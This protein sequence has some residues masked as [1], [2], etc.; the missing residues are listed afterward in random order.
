MKSHVKFLL[1]G[2]KNKLAGPRSK[3]AICFNF[4]AIKVQKKLQKYYKNNF[5]KPPK[6]VLYFK[7]MNKKLDFWTWQHLRKQYKKLLLLTTFFLDI[8]IFLF[9]WR[10]GNCMIRWIMVL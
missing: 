1:L 2:M 3:I 4:Q 9:Y 5:K 6:T 7:K 10:L 8:W